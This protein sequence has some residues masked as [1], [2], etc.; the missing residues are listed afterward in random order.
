MSDEQS[1]T[2]DETA[3]VAEG[4]TTE[5]TTE[6]TTEQ[7]QGESFATKTADEKAEASTQ[8]TDYV[9]P[10]VSLPKESMVPSSALEGI[11]GFVKENKLGKDAA[12]GVIKMADSVISQHEAAVAQR[13][14]AV[15]E[16]GRRSIMSDPILGGQNESQTKANCALFRQKFGSPEF[17]SLLDS[18]LGDNPDFVRVMNKVAR[19]IKDDKIEQGQNVSKKDTPLSSLLYAESTG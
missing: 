18:G 1:T 2:T 12:D 9:A 17:D 14:E 7:A 10:D 11:Q 15:R 19:S 4:Q 13:A 6:T 8:E 3:A 5:Q 16:E